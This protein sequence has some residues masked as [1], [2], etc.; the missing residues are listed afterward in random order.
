MAKERCGAV[1]GGDRY[2]FRCLME[3]FDLLQDV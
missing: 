1:R 2:R 3:Y